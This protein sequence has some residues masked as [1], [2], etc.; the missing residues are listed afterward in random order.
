M[1]VIST[2]IEATQ[3]LSEAMIRL[4]RG[5]VF[6]STL[7]FL[8]NPQISDDPVLLTACTDGTRI[9]LNPDYFKSL[10]PQEQVALLKHEVLHVAFE[11]NFRRGGRRPKRWNIACD[12]IVNQ[13][14]KKE[15]GMLSPDDA[16]DEAYK[17]MIEEEL[18]ETLP[19][20]IED[21]FVGNLWDLRDMM[22]GR[23]TPEA[24]AK[25][26]G[27]VLQAAHT[28]RMTQGRL[29]FGI[30]RYLDEILQPEQDW[31][32]LLAEHLT[33]Q[34]KSDYDWMR[35]NRR[36]S[37]HKAYLPAIQQI[38]ALDHVAIVVDT[39]GSIGEK[40]L[41]R[42]IGEILGIVE[43]CYPR[44]LSIIPCD[45]EVYPALVFDSVP[46]SAEVMT[47]LQTS[48]A[49]KGGGGTDMPV[50]LDWIESNQT[51]NTPPAVVLVMTDGYTDFGEE[52]HYPVIWCITADASHVA[53]PSW[54]RVVRID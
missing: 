48:G 39:S 47:Q 45:A 9:L 34:A 51:F 5:D 49:L 38:G 6:F 26:R 37:V 7:A 32:A 16:Y 21:K 25:I 54:G 30:E 46:Q 17:G 43:V 29:P 36:N 42:F 13:I 24:R 12:Y 41:A 31:R 22:E 10:N 40:E 2:D 11:H 35:P 1:S 23:L 8:L 28:A 14:I 50:A 33:A 20:D 19:A 53:D 18:Y 3:A 4:T 52:R 44:T 27:L 15:G